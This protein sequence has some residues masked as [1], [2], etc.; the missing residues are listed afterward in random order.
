MLL[1]E[2]LINC[3]I[4]FQKLLRLL[5]LRIDISRLLHSIIAKGIIEFFKK[6]VCK[7]KTE[8]VFGRSCH[9]RA[10]LQG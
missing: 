8:Y 10:A 6:V 3:R 9:A 4:L 7:V 1:V 5:G 2:G